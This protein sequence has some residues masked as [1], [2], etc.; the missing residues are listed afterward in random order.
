MQYPLY[1]NGVIMEF[2]FQT[3]HSPLSP[4]LAAH[5]HYLQMQYIWICCQLLLQLLK[6]IFNVI[7]NLI[8]FT[9]VPAMGIDTSLSGAVVVKEKKP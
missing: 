4:L 5:F 7:E 6:F 2:I 1:S 8:P 9:S 3:K